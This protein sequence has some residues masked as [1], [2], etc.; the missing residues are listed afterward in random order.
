M[1][2]IWAIFGSE[3]DVAK[4]IPSALSI[5]HRGPDQFRIQNVNH[6]KNCAF[7]FHRLAIME[8][9]Q[10]MQP[11][12]VHTFP[13]YV[14]CYNGEIYNYKLV[15]RAILVQSFYLAYFKLIAMSIQLQTTA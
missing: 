15:S 6:Y 8:D 13:H 1:C 9:L 11:F 5:A 7:G 3:Q 4:Q 10:G 14:L 12:R 2:G